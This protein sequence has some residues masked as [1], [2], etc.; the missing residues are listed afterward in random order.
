MDL[1]KSLELL[2]NITV[3]ANDEIAQAQVAEIIQQSQTKQSD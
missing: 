2:G 3:I 1:M